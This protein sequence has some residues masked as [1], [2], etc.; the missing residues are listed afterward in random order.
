MNR[1]LIALSILG[2]LLAS[3]GLGFLGVGY[4]QTQDPVKELLIREITVYRDAITRILDLVTDET[5]YIQEIRDYLAT[6]NATDLNSLSQEELETIRDTLKD[7]FDTL[8]EMVSVDPTIGEEV[9]KRIMEE[10]SAVIELI[11][12]KYNMTS[13]RELYDQVRQYIA[14]GEVDKAL[15]ILGELDKVLSEVSVDTQS[16]E[17]ISGIL[18]MLRSLSRD[19]NATSVEALNLSIE[20][21][22]SAIEVL[23]DVKE[24]LRSINASEESILAVDLAISTLNSTVSILE[25]V[26]SKVGDTV[27]PGEVG[28]AVNTT[29]TAELLSEIAEYRWKVSALLNESNRLENMS[30]AMNKSYLLTLIEEAR[31][32]LVNASNYLNKSEAAAVEGNLTEAF[33]LFNRA[34]VAVDYAEEILEDVAKVLGTEL[35]YKDEYMEKPLPMLAGK[36]EDLSGDIQELMAE[37]QRLMNNSEVQNNN[38]TLTMVQK[39]LE[40][41]NNASTLIDNAWIQFYAG[42]YTEALKLYRE[43][44]KMYEAA[45]LNIEMVREWLDESDDRDVMGP[46]LDRIYEYK[47]EIEE[48]STWALSLY[49]KAVEKNNSEA[50]QLILDAQEKL[51]NASDLLYQVSDLLAIGAYNEASDILSQVAMLI[52]DARQNLNKAAAKLDAMMWDDGDDDDTDDDSDD[53]KGDDREGHDDCED[54][55]NDGDGR[56]EGGDREGGRDDSGRRNGEDR[57]RGDEDERE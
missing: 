3:I 24:Y 32:V 29:M 20:N 23:I 2:M 55:G 28:K 14:T 15:E 50:A 44:Y 39:A 30:L 18:D 57:D 43:A 35:K 36:L 11:V 25:N 48:L 4:A 46:M 22:K 33:N 56:N 53:G 19:G 42:N 26:K 5:P 12:E 31:T 8:R 1:G 6:L 37:A 47:E 38:V 51:K 52:S 45:E 10:V 9:R 17:I 13:M 7:Y 34:K 54:C 41:L 21:I 49:N 40:Y 16:E 27:V